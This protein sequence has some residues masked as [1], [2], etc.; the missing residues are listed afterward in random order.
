MPAYI[1][2][3]GL[4]AIES[5]SYTASLGISP[6]V[7]TVVG[8]PE[9]AAPEPAGDLVFGDAADPASWITLPDCRLEQMT[10]GKA[11]GGNRLTCLIV[12]RRWRWQIGPSPKHAEFNQLDDHAKL[13]PWTVRSP[14]QMAV[15]LLR[16]M[17]EDEPDGGWDID[18]PGGLA[19]EYEEDVVPV[20]GPLDTVI[21]PA[22]DYLHVGENLPPTGTNPPVVW[23]GEPAA[24]LLAQLCDQYGRAVCLD[25]LSD[26]VRVVKLGDGE[27]LPAGPL[28]TTQGGVRPDQIP[29][30]VRVVGS[31][32]RYQGRFTFRPVGRDW[33][34]SWRPVNELSYAPGEEGDPHR[35][36]RCSPPLFPTV[37]GTDR[38]SYQQAVRLAQETVWRAY[39][40]VAVDPAGW[41]PADESPVEEETGVPVAGLSDDPDE[42]SELV[43]NRF[44]V[45][46]QGTRPEQ[47]APRPPDVTRLDPQTGRPFAREIYDGYS[48]DR[49][50]QAFGSLHVSA[51]LAGERLVWANRPGFDTNGNSGDNSPFYVPFKVVDAKRQVVLFDA[52]VFRLETAGDLEP[53]IGGDPARRVWTACPVVIETGAL[54]LDADTHS[55]IRHAVEIDVPGGTGPVR[56]VVI[57]QV[58][59]EVIGEY[60]D[61]HTLTNWR[62][63]DDYATA[64]A[65]FYGEAIRDTYQIPE[66]LTNTYLGVVPIGIDGRVR[67]V[68]WSLSPAAYV[69][70]A[71]LG[72]EHARTVLPYPARRRKENLPPDPT[73]SFLNR[74]GLAA[75]AVWKAANAAGR[76]LSNALSGFGRGA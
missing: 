14:Y 69:T 46:L 24:V 29:E 57:E 68:T 39:Q 10:G 20:P 28:A 15:I 6:G 75:G 40:L 53:S 2:Y 25:P 67:Q 11:P 58:Q 7:A 18:L 60:A 38:L 1:T 55:P 13:V 22:D 61:D 56:T 47:T 64:A 52:P 76:A 12:D 33:D 45:I 48:Q 59:R 30:K 35:W 44:R 65:T 27:G 34:G 9:L 72:T 62:D 26:E 16:A 50:P 4:V 5:V 17:G 43:T 70:T 51:A 42:L 3:P 73:E 54:I 23:A 74:A 41:D 66:S 37:K 63:N 32:V 49:P 71:S 19:A 31:P 36:A 21:D 8:F